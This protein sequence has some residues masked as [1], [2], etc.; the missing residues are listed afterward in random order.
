MTNDKTKK[1]K[2]QIYPLGNDLNNFKFGV[3]G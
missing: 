2:I 3:A 1:S